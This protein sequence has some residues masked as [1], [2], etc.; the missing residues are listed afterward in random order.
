MTPAQG[1]LELVH[2]ETPEW[3]PG[4]DFTLDTDAQTLWATQQQMASAF[5]ITAGTVGE[6]LGNIFR[7]GELDQTSVTRKFRVT[8]T[9]GKRYNTLHYNL[10]AILSV[11]YRVSSKRGTA[12]RRWATAIL[13]DYVTQG[14][15]LDEQRLRDDPNALREL[16]ARVRAIRAE[17]KNV[18]Q[19]VRDVFA[20]GS[21]DYDKDSPTVRS[22]YARL[23]DKF[24]FAVAGKTASEIKLERADHKKPSMGLQVMKGEFPERTDA[25]IAKNYLHEQELYSLHILC[26]QFLLFVESKAIRGQQLTMLE[27]S[28]KFDD[29]LR[30][31]GHPVF[32]GY[33]DYLAQRAK[34]HASVEFDAWRER[35]RGMT[36]EQKRLA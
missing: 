33:Q 35:V 32:F 28:N 8:A 31:Q 11:G 34:S 20:F 19:G 2:Y 17:E 14:F 26:E 4:V 15:A 3:G 22:F 36:P 24:L 18:Y 30:F 5:G 1:E 25:D 12:F 6:H 9:D 21:V 29:L 23:Q 27:L 16:A 10:D 7:E 13:S